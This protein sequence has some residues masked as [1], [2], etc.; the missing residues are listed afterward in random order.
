MWLIFEIVNYKSQI[1]GYKSN[2]DNKEYDTFRRECKFIIIWL[3][4]GK[5]KLKL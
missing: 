2:N 3:N 1:Y 4:K 5:V